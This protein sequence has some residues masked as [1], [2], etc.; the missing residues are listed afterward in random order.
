MSDTPFTHI[1]ILQLKN[2]VKQAGAIAL[3]YFGS[4]VKNW[5]KPDDT[6][7]S[8]ADIAVN[9]FLEKELQALCPT[10][11]WL[12]EETIDDDAR[13]TKEYL[14][15]VDPID[16]TKAFIIAK[17]E[18]VVSVAI[19]KNGRPIVGLIYNPVTEIMYFAS[20]GMGATANDVKIVPQEVEHIKNANILSYK[21]HF[22]RMAKHANYCWPDMEY[23]IV[24][25]MAL[26]VSLVASGMYHAMVSF[27]NKGE[28]DIAAADIIIHEAGGKITD[29]KGNMLTYNKPV[30]DLPHMVAAA[31]NLHRMIIE[32]TADF[33]FP[34]NKNPKS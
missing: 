17:A 19:I 12:S 10:F 21:F 9:D 32:H 20:K 31:P 6:P 4:N 26:R 28:W 34:A 8:E 3:G 7:I 30:P 2:I 1:Q 33:N 25:S 29:G 14:W 5:K 13:L 15:V 16:G 11:G 27:T 23:D 24:N 22:E 18:W